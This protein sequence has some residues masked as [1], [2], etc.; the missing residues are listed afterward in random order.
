MR[1]KQ[2]MGWVAALVLCAQAAH[3]DDYVAPMFEP[4]SSYIE[5]N[6]K[7][8]DPSSFGYSKSGFVSETYENVLVEPDADGSSY[9]LPAP[10]PQLAAFRGYRVMDC[11]SGKFLAIG[12]VWRNEAAQLL[13][14][15]FLR[16][17]AQ[18]EQPITLS[19]VKRAAQAIYKGRR[20]VT[21]MELRET[22]KT[23]AC[24]NYTYS[25]E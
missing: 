2:A 23:C 9:W 13:A 16:D 15:E 22:Q 17:K 8:S 19:D 4:C 11:R 10:V 18:K 1:E 14:T 24:E 20:D 12:T 21:I 25:G 5:S 7:A 6:M 3:A